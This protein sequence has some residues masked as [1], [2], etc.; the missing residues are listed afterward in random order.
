MSFSL[1]LVNKVIL[2]ILVSLIVLLIFTL[3]RPLPINETTMIEIEKGYGLNQLIDRLSEQGLVNRPLI[4]KGYVKVFKRSD[5]I[6]AGEYLISKTN[7]ALQLIQKVSEGSVYY[8]QIRLREGSTINELID[9]FK[10]NTV[11]K[12]DKNFDDKNKIRSDLGLEINSL[13]GLF[14]PDTYN[15]IKG[16][17]YL[18]ILKRSNLKHQK[19]LN[20]LWNQ[21]NINLPFKNSYEALIL[22][23]IIEKE[24]TE[25]KQ[26]A[27]VF[28]RRLKLRMKLQSDPTI[29]FALGDEYDGDIKSSHIKMKHPYNTYYIQGLPPGP[30]GLVSE[31][32]IQAALNPEEGNSLFF[33]SKG[34]GTHYFSDTLEEHNQAV[35]RFQL[36]K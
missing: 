7:N 30:I 28:V 35:Q 11:L 21:R 4:L 18:D 33:V 34:D 1:S 9:L 24:G 27:G 29:I 19:I 25:K 36:N 31:S 17:S 32:S 20:K 26:I 6:K 22:A 13:E 12:K 3:Y 23:S 15:Y 16:D 10:N 5:D 8:H 14:H 2:A